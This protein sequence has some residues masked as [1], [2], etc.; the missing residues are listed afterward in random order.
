MI[1]KIII[2]FNVIIVILLFIPIFPKLVLNNTKDNKFNVILNIKRKEF[3]ISYIHSVNKSL[4]R[5]YYIIDDDKNIILEKTRFFSY[6]AGIA[7]PI[8]DEKIIITDKY[9]EINNINRLI[10]DFY[11]FVGTIA[12]HTIYVDN[13]AIELN[14]IFKPQSSINIKYRYVSIF[15]YIK[16]YL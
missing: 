12:N 16:S 11:L 3:I 13:K 5:D 7:E 14:T 9:I 8:N 6:G 4:V 15:N 1:K 10:K 2:F